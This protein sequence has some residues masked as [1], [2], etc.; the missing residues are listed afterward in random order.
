MT[1]TDEARARRRPRLPVVLREEPQYRLLFAGQLLSVVGDRMTAIVLPFAVLAVGGG[2][3]G[4][5]IVSTAQFAPFAVLALPAGVWS[6]RFDRKRILIAS[7]TVRLV[8]QLVAAT[9]LLTGTAGVTSLAILAALYGA[10]DA[11]FAPAF[12]GLLPRTVAMHN[13]QGANAV[14]GATRSTGAIVGPVLAG[15]VI[16]YAGGPGVAVL[17]DA[18]TF[19]VSVA[20]LVFLRPHPPQSGT[21]AEPPTSTHFFGGL[22]EGWVEVR[23]RPWVL[24]FL[25]GMGCYSVIVLPAIFV[26]GPVLAD[27]EMGGARAWSIITAGFGVGALLGNFVLLRWRPRHALRIASLML[28]GSSCQAGI[29]GSGLGVWVIAGLE[30]LAGV[31]VTLFFTLWDTTLQEHIPDRALSRVSSYDYLLS[32]G[33]IP[34]G[35]IVAGLVSSAV[36]LRPALIGMSVLGIGA[37]VVVAAVPSIRHLRRAGVEP[38]ANKAVTGNASHPSVSA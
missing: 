23:S 6:D 4:V 32:V 28:I 19:A 24:W 27:R 18:G 15:L 17:V 1:A 8:C 9:L 12:T 29:I 25:G 7:D 11:F 5:A 16:A 35:N 37:S 26:L 14:L 38:T 13:V 30:V 10:A 20:C 21:D 22:K 34:V 3:A 2:L 36:G 31:C 33:C